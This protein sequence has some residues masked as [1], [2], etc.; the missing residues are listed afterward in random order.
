M[1]ANLK[2]ANKGQIARLIHSYGPISVREIS[3]HSML[4]VPCVMKH[5]AEMSEQGMIAGKV[6]TLAA[7]GRK[8]KTVSINPDY[9]YVLAIDLG[10]DW[11]ELG[12]GDFSG[13]LAAQRSMPFAEGRTGREEINSVIS[14]ASEML[15]QACVPLDRLEAVVTGN[16]G[17]VNP[18]TG[19]MRM[20]AASAKWYDI[21][22]RNV[23]EESFGCRTL[24]RNDVNLS[25]IGEQACGSGKGYDNFLYIRDDVGLKAGIV[26]QGRL[27][28]GEKNAA[29]E[30]GLG[31]IPGL[32]GAPSGEGRVSRIEERISM[33]ALVREAAAKL[34]G[35]PG[36]ILYSLAGRDAANV[37]VDTIARALDDP[38]SFVCDLVQEKVNLLAVAVANLVLTLD[39]SLVI[40]GGGI[41]QLHNHVLRPMRQALGELLSDPPTLMPS[42]L[43]KSACLLG[44]V[45]LGLDH[46][47]NAI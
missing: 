44:A 27:Y 33:G 15:K 4:S 31:I 24:V 13:G 2:D 34:P 32:S 16:P 1:A 10:G 19:T 5:I 30:I 46:A 18:E 20:Q 25:A 42:A 11:A 3:R 26:L 36:D 40:F 35:Y 6:N 8:P 7:A 29:G 45:R 37:S 28:E 9:R 38:K 22:V 17:V 12:L 21:P 43:G 14:E 23:F 39:V 47:F 41:L